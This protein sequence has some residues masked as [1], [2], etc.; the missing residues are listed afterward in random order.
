MYNK[1]TVMGRIV[2]D[3][4]LRSTPSG[5]N[6]LLFR[7]AVDRRYQKQGEE[8][9]TDFFNVAAWKNNCEFIRKYFGKGRMILIEG[10]MTT[11]QYKDKNGNDATW[12][13]LV[14][15]RATFTGEPKQSGEYE[16]A[17]EPLPPIPS[18]P[19][20]S[21]AEFAPEVTDDDYPF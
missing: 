3:P 18:N 4:E 5:A 11:R 19:I 1:M 16:K 21:V 12:Y 14:V 20:G 17:A 13:E 2:N 6:V 8:R 9:K 7:V 15:E 10:E